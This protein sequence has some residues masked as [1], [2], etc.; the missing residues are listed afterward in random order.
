MGRYLGGE[1]VD[2]K[3]KAK[4]AEISSIFAWF[5]GLVLS[6]GKTG[7][8]GNMTVPNKKTFALFLH[9]LESSSVL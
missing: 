4:L 1:G 2:C 7:Q 8:A 5:N 3:I 6:S 9:Y